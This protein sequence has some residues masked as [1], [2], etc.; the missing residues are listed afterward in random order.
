M[1]VI[2]DVTVADDPCVV[3]GRENKEKGEQTCFNY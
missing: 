1:S 2:V 3:G